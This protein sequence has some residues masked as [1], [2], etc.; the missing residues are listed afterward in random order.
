MY[1]C[2]LFIIMLANKSI[3]S[4]RAIR[5]LSVISGYNKPSSSLPSAV[6]KVRYSNS[7]IEIYKQIVDERRMC[8]RLRGI[9]LSVAAFTAEF[10]L[11]WEYRSA[12]FAGH[13]WRNRRWRQH[14][15]IPRYRQSML[16]THGAYR[17]HKT[18]N[19][20]TTHLGS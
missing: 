9:L 17:R 13:G 6:S 2:N 3:I 18:V 15:F 11:Y 16:L 10:C 1:S 4:I 20:E 19:P 12:L 14:I 5:V 7:I 8:L